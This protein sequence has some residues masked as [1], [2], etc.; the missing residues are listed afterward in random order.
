MH[1]S[2]T[3]SSSEE[4]LSQLVDDARQHRRLLDENGQMYCPNHIPRGLRAKYIVQ[5]SLLAAYTS[6]GLYVDDIYIPGK[7]GPGLHF[8]GVAALLISAAVL[9]AVLNMS[10][11]LVDH[12]DKRDNELNYKRFARWT[13]ILGW[14]LLVCAYGAYIFIPMT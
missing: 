8:H 7:R 11:V 6:Y 2:S 13:C 5:A 3:Q 12:Y 4:E 10:S 1:H 14:V 9:A